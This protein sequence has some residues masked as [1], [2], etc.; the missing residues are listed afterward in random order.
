M[1][2]KAIAGFVGKYKKTFI[3]G[4]IVLV[5]LYM[6]FGGPAKRK[7]KEQVT[8][9]TGNITNEE[10][11]KAEIE[12]L[13][14][15]I[16]ELKKQQAQPQQKKEEELRKGQKTEKEESSGREKE[17]GKSLSELEK[18]IKPSG[19]TPSQ[20]G[21]HQHQPKGSEMPVEIGIPPQKPSPPRLIKIDISEVTPP[22]KKEQPHT[23]KSDL[24][25]PAGSFGSFTT[26]SSVYGPETGEQMPVSGVIDK[27][28]VGP[29]KSSIPLTGCFWQGKARG[30]TGEKCADIKVVK[31]SCVWP[32]G[33]SFE[34]D[35]VGYV[36]AENGAFCLPGRVERHSAEFFATVGITSFLE[37]LTT[38][39]S[40]AQE[41]TSLAAS[42]LAVQSA[43][44]VTGS[45]AAYGLLKGAVDFAG[46]AK[47]FYAA[48]LQS[49]VP[50]VLVPA[51]TKGYVYM[52]SGLRI[53]GGRNALAGNSGAGY[54]DSYNLSYRK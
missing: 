26:S 48:Q 20:G 34:S 2:A 40:K 6:I 39:M 45:A 1:D 51:G 18:M 3:V 32:D 4:A 12:G 33:S 49:L 31:I 42:G 27:A 24:Y 52:T 50:A 15:S 53:T 47:Q 7:I 37:G 41:A 54:Y 23:E 13:K 19:K 5:V 29:N 28:F 36:T 30:I 21:E 43:T 14:K 8:K 16:E 22:E 10:R 9:G 25:L 46:A 11:T 35:I 44:N 38:G 17:S